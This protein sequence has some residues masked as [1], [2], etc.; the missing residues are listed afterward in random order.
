M[1]PPTL[2]A[3]GNGWFGGGG[4]ALP[5][6]GAGIAR[7]RGAG[8]ADLTSDKGV[9]AQVVVIVAIADNSGARRI[10]RN[11]EVIRKVTI[12]RHAADN[13]ARLRDIRSM[14][15]M[16]AGFR[17]AEDRVALDV[18]SQRVKDMPIGRIVA[19][20]KL[21]TAVPNHARWCRAP[22]RSSSRERLPFRF[23]VH[24]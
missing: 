2:A 13:Q 16:V 22:A 8:P 3:V 19:G 11:L 4:N 10:E 20:R 21:I 18:C 12:R 7:A 1:I 17:L 6:T 24:H 14:N 23:P 9:A 15:H 5:S